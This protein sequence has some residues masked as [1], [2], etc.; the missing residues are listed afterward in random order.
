MRISFSSQVQ[1]LLVWIGTGAIAQLVCLVKVFHQGEWHGYLTNELNPAVLPA[2]YVVAL[3][4]QRWRIEDAYNIVK[5]LLG[6][7]YF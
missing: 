3:Y 7:A 6:L 4:Y 1:D 5:R 2:Q